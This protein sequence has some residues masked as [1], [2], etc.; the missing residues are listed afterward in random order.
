MGTGIDSLQEED[1][2]KTLKTKDCF[3]PLSMRVQAIKLG[4]ELETGNEKRETK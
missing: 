4:N 3:A 1:N 2:D